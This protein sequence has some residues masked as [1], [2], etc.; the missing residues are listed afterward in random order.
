MTFNIIKP[1]TSTVVEP[2]DLEVAKTA[3]VTGMVNDTVTNLHEAF[4][5]TGASNGSQVSGLFSSLKKE[6]ETLSMLADTLM[7]EGKTAT[8]IVSAVNEASTNFD[9]NDIKTYK[10]EIH[11]TLAD[12][13]D[14]LSG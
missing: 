11:G 6:L 4:E 9:A 1:K 3:L 5:V 10:L 2:I 14:S 8:Q 13:K 7:S 12:W